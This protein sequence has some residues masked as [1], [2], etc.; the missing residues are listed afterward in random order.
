MEIYKIIFNTVKKICDACVS[1]I[2][3]TTILVGCATQ[4]TIVLKQPFVSVDKPLAQ[5]NVAVIRNIHLY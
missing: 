5:I 3:A 4:E 1:I 2:V